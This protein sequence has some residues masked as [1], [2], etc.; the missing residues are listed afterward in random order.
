MSYGHQND[1][2]YYQG[3]AQ[4]SGHGYGQ[5]SSAHPERATWT[6]RT[7]RQYCQSVAACIATP[8]SQVTD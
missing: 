1:N 7:T 4:E 2:P 8:K 6:T 3:S 5:V